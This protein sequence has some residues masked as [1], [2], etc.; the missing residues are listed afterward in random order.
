MT[1]RV[2]GVWLQSAEE[3]SRPMHGSSAG[4][5][6]RVR[7]NRALKPLPQPR[8]MPAMCHVQIEEK[9][10]G[11]KAQA[12]LPTQACCGALEKVGGLGV[13]WLPLLR[14]L[15]LR[16]VVVVVAVRW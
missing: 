9:A 4:L 12:G 14:L 10:G 13:P 2:S 15:L 1:L 11:L 8:L 7:C 16:V 6:G 5:R 3:G